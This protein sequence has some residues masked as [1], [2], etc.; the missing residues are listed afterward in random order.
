MILSDTTAEFLALD[1]DAAIQQRLRR[2]L[3]T[4]RGA[5]KSLPDYGTSL[6]TLVGQAVTEAHLATLSGE[7]AT[8]VGAILD[9]E[10]L[11][12]EQPQ[13]GTLAVTINQRYVVAVEA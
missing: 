12:I 4:P 7:I 3:L 1:S 10:S 6:P 11:T 9:I 2:V 13:V 5:V 8:A